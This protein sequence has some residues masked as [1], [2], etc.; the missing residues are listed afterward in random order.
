MIRTGFGR[1]CSATFACLGAI[2]AMACQSFDCDRRHVATEKRLIVLS[3]QAI[4]T[5]VCQQTGMSFVVQPFN[6]GDE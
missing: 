3:K 1:V 2:K 5:T 6:A 4:D